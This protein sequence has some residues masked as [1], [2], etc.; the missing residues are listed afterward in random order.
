[1]FII[2]FSVVSTELLSLLLSFMHYLHFFCLSCF[3]VTPQPPLTQR[4]FVT[5]AVTLRGFHIPTTVTRAPVS[6]RVWRATLVCS[7]RTARRITSQMAPVA[8]SPVPAT[9]TVQWTTSV[10]GKAAF[11]VS[12]RGQPLAKK[13]VCFVNTTEE[14][15]LISVL[16]L[17]SKSDKLCLHIYC[18]SD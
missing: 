10:T 17:T 16:C 11:S 5:A 3:F 8:A 7:V 6:V 12:P 13:S 15:R 4:S 2:L 18:F 1:M 9:H 14:T